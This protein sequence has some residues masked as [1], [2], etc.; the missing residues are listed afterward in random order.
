ME[1]ALSAGTIAVMSTPD[2]M[3]KRLAELDQR[4][5]SARPRITI[6]RLLRAAGYKGVQTWYDVLANKSP[7]ETVEAF[8]V[9]LD[10]LI[11][12]PD[13]IA[14]EPT[15]VVAPSPEDLMKVEITGDFGVNVVVSAPIRD[16][17]ALQDFVR[18][19]MRDLRTKRESGE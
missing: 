4:R 8:E 14:D 7:I 2:P 12:H 19:L 13:D 5:R 10:D 18:D 1:T 15:H 17:E 9:A 11:N 3:E 6:E 16:K